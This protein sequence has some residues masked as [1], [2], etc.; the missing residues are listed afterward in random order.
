VTVLADGT[1]R[2]NGRSSEDSKWNY[3]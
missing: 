1:V 2:A 3:S